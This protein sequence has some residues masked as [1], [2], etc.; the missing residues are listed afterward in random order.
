MIKLGV[1][2]LGIDCYTTR[3]HYIQ[4][5]KLLDNVVH[6]QSRTT[7]VYNESTEALS[8]RYNLDNGQAEAL[9]FITQGADI[10]VLVGRPGAGKSYLLKPLKD[11]Y[12]KNNCQVLGAALSGKVAKA[13]ETDTGIPSSTIAS[14]TYRLSKQQLHLTKEHV[15]IIDEAGMV[16]FANMAYLLDAANKARAKIILVG[17][18]DQLKPINKGEI[19][20]GITATTGYIELDNIRRQIDAGDRQASLDLAKGRIAE[21]ITYYAEKGAIQFSSTPQDAIT[22]MVEFWDTDLN[23]ERIKEHVMLAFTRVA[24]AS[25]N[26]EA[27][28]AMQARGIVGIKSEGYF[29]DNGVKKIDLAVGE[30]I[31]LRQNDKTLGIRNG[32]LATITLMGQHQ[33]TAKLDSGETVV[34]PKSYQFIDYGYALT[35]HKSQGMTVDNASVLIDSTYWDRALSFVAMTRHRKSLTLFADKTQHPTLERLTQTLSR[36]ST[37]DNVIDWPL[38]YAIR[39]GFEPDSLIGRAINRIAGAAHQV[40][41]KWNYVVNYEAYLRSENMQLKRSERQAL[42]S[43]AKGVAD[44]LD[45]KS[46]VSQLLATIEKEAKQKGVD[47]SALPAFEEFYKRSLA[48]DKQAWELINMHAAPLEKQPNRPHVLEAIKR[49]SVRYERYQAVIAV[50]SQPLTM[51]DS[52]KLTALA[53]TVDLRKD[54]IHIVRV[55]A[56]NNKTSTALYQQIE[57]LQKTHRQT[58]WNQLKKEFPIL[59]DYAQLLNDRRKA[60]TFKGGQLDKALLIKACEITGNKALFDRLQRELPKITIAIKNRINGHDKEQGISR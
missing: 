35:V 12:Q 36:V 18:P 9:S 31:L 57:T 26:E 30:R 14:L 13:L 54:Y 29:S 55:A 48:R 7:H 59:A 19:F 50:A 21:A 22:Q 3:N 15:L 42:R 11:Y 8:K 32:D 17:D 49:H 40:K 37:R 25:L 38:D 28:I 2:D 20:R 5:A 27:R 6:L 51:P 44:Y 47:K 45:E 60:P 16:D 33:F 10:S 34:I 23:A 46:A 1:N 39:C 53:A 52:K 58:V 4:E 24:V 41:D 56:T 43:V